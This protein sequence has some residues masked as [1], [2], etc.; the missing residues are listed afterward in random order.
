[1]KDFKKF[2]KQNKYV[3]II[4]CIFII[5]TVLLAQIVNVFFPTKGEAIYG[6]RLDGIENVKIPSQKYETIEHELGSEEFVEKAK[7]ELKGR[8]INVT[9]TLKDEASK[10]QAKSLPNK[11]L[12]Q[13]DEKQKKYYDIQ[14][15][16]KK[17]NDDASFPIIAYKHHQK[18]QFSFTKDR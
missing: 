6:N 13:L 1:M 3:I 18:E 5:L 8:L 4:L 16:L 9:V 10:D 2:C 11:V 14:V 17:T 15:F 7:A 12:E